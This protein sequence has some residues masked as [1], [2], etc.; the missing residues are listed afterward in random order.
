MT[1]MVDNEFIPALAL[2]LEDEDRKEAHRLAPDDPMPGIHPG[3][4]WFHNANEETSSPI[5]CKYIVNDGLKIITPYYQLDM[6]YC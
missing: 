2:V 1:E 5:F 3:L 6:C 4:G